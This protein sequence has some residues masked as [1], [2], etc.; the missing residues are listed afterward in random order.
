[1]GNPPQGTKPVVAMRARL[2]PNLVV[3]GGRG[4]NNALNQIYKHCLLPEYVHIGP[5]NQGLA[6]NLRQ[7]W[8]QNTSSRMTL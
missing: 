2:K 5:L 7:K 1:M 6:S 8:S 3:L 4:T